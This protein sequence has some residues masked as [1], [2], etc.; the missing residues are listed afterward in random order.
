[1]DGCP[2]DEKKK[3]FGIFVTK[4]RL[5]SILLGLE[6]VL[7][8]FI[9]SVENFVPKKNSNSKST[10]SK[11]QNIGTSEEATSS[12]TKNLKQTI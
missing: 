7:K 11:Q 8:R 6:P 10:T 9:L 3:I 5:V 4:P 2:D 12:E 1:M